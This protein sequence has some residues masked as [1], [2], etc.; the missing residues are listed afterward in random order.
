MNLRSILVAMLS[1]RQIKKHKERSSAEKAACSKHLGR[2]MACP[3]GL[4][5]TRYTEASFRRCFRRDCDHKYGE[6]IERGTSAASIAMQI[7]S[8]GQF[9][10]HPANYKTAP[11]QLSPPLALSTGFKKAHQY[12]MD[13]HKRYTCRRVQ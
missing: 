13:L 4:P 2:L 11:C 7:I 6:T 5:G 10:E 1:R 8:R 12:R 3:N 9:K